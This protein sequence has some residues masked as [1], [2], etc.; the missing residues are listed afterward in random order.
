[1]SVNGPHD[2]IAGSALYL[3][4]PPL[5]GWLAAI[6]A[7]LWI[8]A[9]LTGGL[10]FASASVGAYLIIYLTTASTIRLPNLTRWGDLSFGTYIWAFPVQQAVS[11]ALGTWA[12]WYLNAAISL[13]IVLAIAWASWHFIE[14][15][16]LSLKGRLATRRDTDLLPTIA[17]RRGV[18]QTVDEI[19]PVR[20]R[21]RA[22]E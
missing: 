4:R 22:D 5:R 10:R 13:P 9:F 14:A 3:W 1:V 8:A 16:A 17:G 18:I 7:L 12:C 2:F 15:P 19:D 21:D 20:D 11:A 6:C